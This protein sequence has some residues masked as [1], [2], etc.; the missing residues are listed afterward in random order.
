ML[1]CSRALEDG[2]GEAVA[3]ENAHLQ[4]LIQ[5]QRSAPDKERPEGRAADRQTHL[6]PS[7]AHPNPA[8]SLPARASSASDHRANVSGTKSPLHTSQTT[9]HTHI[10]WGQLSGLAQGHPYTLPGVKLWHCGP[11]GELADRKRSLDVGLQI[12]DD[13][14]QKQQHQPTAPL[15]PALMVTASCSKSTPL[16][17]TFTHPHIY[18]HPV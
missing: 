18:Q 4:S 8:R 15:A 1:P 9:L 11:W 5:A 10:P 2:A 12:R 3:Q 16:E 13:P 17:L 14:T 6:G 7:E